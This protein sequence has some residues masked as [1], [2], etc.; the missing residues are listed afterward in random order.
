MNAFAEGARLLFLTLAG[1][2]VMAGSA[3]AQDESIME[4]L[5]LTLD[6]KEQVR[7][8]NQRFRAQTTD[9]RNDLKKL[10][11]QEKRLR[12]ADRVSESSLRDVLEQRAKK[13]IELSLAL[14]R[15]S[16]QLEAILTQSQR[17]RLQELKKSEKKRSE[18]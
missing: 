10:I 2:T 15:Y 18:Q 12:N 7:N 1:L 8:L 17:R 13:E 9:L 6:Q 11:D 4:Q 16:E 5:G 3:V 14:T